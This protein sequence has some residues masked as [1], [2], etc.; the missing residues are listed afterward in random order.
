MNNNKSLKHR[1]VKGAQWGLLGTVI[2]G[3]MQVAVMVIMARLIDP[4]YF[5]ILAMAQL[6]IRF[7]TYFA[8]FG[9][10][11]TL[12]RKKKL[13]NQEIRA[14]FYASLFFFTLMAAAMWLLAPYSRHLLDAPEMVWVVRLLAV[15]FLLAGLGV[16]SNAMLQREMRFKYLAGTQLTSYFMSYV[17]IGIPLAWLG[18]GIWALVI[19]LMAQSVLRIVMHY[20]A[21]RHSLS[22]VLNWATYREIIS[23]GGQHSLAGFITFLANSVDSFAIG[24]FMGDTM[25]GLYSR[26]KNLVNLPMDLVSQS[27]LRVSFPAFSEEQYDNSRMRTYFLKSVMILG[28]LTFPLGIGFLPVAKDLI[29]VVLGE[30]WV[31]GWPAFVA[32]GMVMPIVLASTLGWM[33]NDVIGSVSKKVAW[34]SV[35]LAVLVGCIFLGFTHGLVGIAVAFFVGQLIKSAIAFYVCRKKSAVYMAGTA[36]EFSAGMSDRGNYFSVD[37]GR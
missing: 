22:P 3:L 26:C 11:P 9:V 28:L 24:K 19:C 32:Y 29:G 17:I 15:N 20:A 16:V 8:N 13:Q 6:F 21:I 2:N 1:S 30:R 33:V 35:S 18:Y 23:F 10:A 31:P 7:A 37:G 14:A 4:R 34:Q 12:I 5:G 25:L 36:V 27:V